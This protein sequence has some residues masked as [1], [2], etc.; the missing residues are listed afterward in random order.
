MDHSETVTELV[1]ALSKFQGAMKSVSK[2]A[3]N[4][5]FRMRYADLDA[6][7]DA[8]RKPLADNGLSLV[9]MTVELDG[10]L[11]LETT[12]YHS[13]GQ[14]LSG[15]YPLTPMKQEKDVGWVLSNDPQTIGSALT[16]ARRYAMSAMLGISADED[17]DAERATKGPR[18]E[19][20]KQTQDTAPAGQGAASAPEDTAGA[21]REFATV[22]TMWKA[23][24]EAGHSSEQVQKAIGLLGTHMAAGGTRGG[25]YDKAIAK[26][27]G[28]A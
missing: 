14:Y 23:L 7:W 2:N 21:S 11:Y 28:K 22:T 12:L 3:A 19:A 8:C 6:I 1:A 20:P 17:D 27:G 18:K 4:P 15:R 5:Y 9:Q 24:E 10:K 26:L 13:T 25:Y 16:Y